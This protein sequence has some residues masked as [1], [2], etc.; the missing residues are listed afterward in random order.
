MADEPSPRS[1]AYDFHSLEDFL[2]ASKLT[3]DE[4][5]DDTWGA[6]YP[7]KGREIEAT[8]LFA[9]I[10][11]FSA[12]TRDMSPGATLLFVNWF[13]T[14]ITA[15]ALRGG[16]GIIDKYIGDE[17]MIVFSKE[18]GSADPFVEA[19]QTACWMAQHDVWSFVPHIGIA[20]G[21][22]MVGYVGTPIKY[23]CSVFGFPVALANRC[24]GVEPKTDDPQYSTPVI[25]PAEEW[26]D[27]DL[28][29]VIPPTDGH[30]DWELLAPQSEDLKNVGTVDVHA[31]VR[32]GAWF[33]SKPVQEVAKETFAQ[34]QEHGRYWEEPDRPAQR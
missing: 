21:R 12:R 11:G 29:E 14:W 31:L 16:K 9:D 20:S 2:I 30:Q 33:P 26:A 1:V 13:F 19:V 27:R 15:E 5:L 10:T 24:A 7:L 28:D 17:A 8:V 4:Q 32:R 34:I 23:N 6:R 25:F 22:V 18:F 3:V